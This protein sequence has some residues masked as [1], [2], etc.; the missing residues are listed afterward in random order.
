MGK[1]KRS[2]RDDD[3]VLRRGGK[4]PDR[5]RNKVPKCLCV[6]VCVWFVLEVI[7]LALCCRRLKCTVLARS[8]RVRRKPLLR[9]SVP[10]I[11]LFP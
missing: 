1:A 8:L 6:C 9:G 4:D 5:P 11:S 3:E 10:L 7:V 2:D